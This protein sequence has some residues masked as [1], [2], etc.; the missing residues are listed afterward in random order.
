MLAR[1]LKDIFSAAHDS[2][3][4]T[5]GVSENSEAANIGYAFEFPFR[6]GLL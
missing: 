1:D 5:R 4:A 6:E 3:F 2:I